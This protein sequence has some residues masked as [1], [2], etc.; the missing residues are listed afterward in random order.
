MDLGLQ[1][2][3]E[4]DAKFTGG[5]IL[6]IK[7]RL[8][9]IRSTYGRHIPKTCALA[10]EF[11]LQHTATDFHPTKLLSKKKRNKKNFQ[12]LR[13]FGGGEEDMV[14]RGDQ[15]NGQRSDELTRYRVPEEEDDICKLAMHW[16][17]WLLLM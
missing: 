7:I 16:V 12:G 8:E 2:P 15:T 11:K 1:C 17:F 13:I 10:L 9:L 5:L 3:A 4:I 14:L 6:S